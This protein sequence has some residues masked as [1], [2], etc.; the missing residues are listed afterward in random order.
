MS[1][2]R[3][4]TQGPH[5]YERAGRLCAYLPPESPS[6]SPR[7]VALGSA[8]RREAERKLGA[9]ELGLPYRPRS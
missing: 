3:R 9:E 7:R 1:K 4:Y 6:G 8:D 2:S 5:I